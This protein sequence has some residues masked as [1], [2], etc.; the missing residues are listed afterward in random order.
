MSAISGLILIFCI[1]VLV[2]LTYLRISVLI[3]A[4]ITAVLL[5][6]IS[7]I[8]VLEALTQSYSPGLADFVKSYFL[9]FAASAVFGKVMEDTGMAASI[10]KYLG[11]RF[12][13]GI[14]IIGVYITTGLLTYGG[15]SLF[16]VVFTMFPIG[17][18]LFKEANVSRHMLP[19][20]I[21]AGLATWSFA[22]MPGSPQ[23][24]VIVASNVLGTTPTS[25]ALLGIILTV[26]YIIIHIAIFLWYDKWNKKKGIGFENDPEVAG[27]SGMFDNRDLPNVWLSFIPMV[28]IV[29]LLNVVKIDIVYSLL[30][31]IGVG[32]VIGWKFVK[33]DRLET[34]NQGVLN[35]IIALL[36]TAAVVGFGSLVKVTPAFAEVR[37]AIL[38]MTGDPVLFFAIATTLLAGAT[39]SGTGGLT[40]A[41][42]TLS[43]D[44]MAMGIP[45]V[46]LHRVSLAACVGLDSLPHNGAVVSCL[47]VCKSDHRRGYLLIFIQ[48]VV[49]TLFVMILAVILSRVLYM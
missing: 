25:G 10:A 28:T 29:V 13:P 26:I 35:A 8:P 44:Y 19:G 32:M 47:N 24:A 16:C 40:I 4:P 31:G 49:V 48:T 46:V 34:F 37:S 42:E 1:V 39:G 3:A 15:I 17:L 9:M 36:N 6:L 38:S 23:A 7:G 5:A 11:K 20:C 14:A 27:I 43:A 21:M 2:V 41:L 33:G 12:G 45:A 22:T 30:G 18:A